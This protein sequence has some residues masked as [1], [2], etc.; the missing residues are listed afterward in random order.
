MC[1]IGNHVYIY[2]EVCLV[3][4]ID[5]LFAFLAPVTERSHFL[6]PL[7][8]TA[9]LSFV[10]LQLTFLV[11]HHERGTQSSLFNDYY[12]HI[13]TLVSVSS[14]SL[15]FQQRHFMVVDEEQLFFI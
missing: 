3:V 5:W 9:C 11:H 6:P 13:P 10:A 12:H 4:D 2:A 14:L 7:Q 15:P 1:F 8:C